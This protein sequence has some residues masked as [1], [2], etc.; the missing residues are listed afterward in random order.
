MKQLKVIIYWLTGFLLLTAV[1]CKKDY[2]NFEKFISNGPVVYP[3]RPDSTVA[4]AGKNRVQLKWPVPSD[5]NILNYKVFW[6]FGADS[7]LV[8]GR[9]PATGD[10]IKIYI[11]NLVEGSYSFTVR[12]YD[13]EDRRSVGT[14]A[15][16][17]VYG[18]I[19][20]STIFNRP[21][22]TKTLDTKTSTASIAWVGIDAKCIGT[23]WNYTNTGGAAANLFSPIGDSTI[24]TSCNVTK[25]I[26]Y[27]SLFLPEA[28]AI[29]TFYTEYKQL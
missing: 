4:L 22:R 11:A 12:S 3:G 25:P 28:N 8:T 23:Q 14:Q 2:H 20:S 24:I 17:N 26:T 19:F 27:R 7:L 10:S 16:G 15:F 1:S 21:V 6:N 5:L 13:K 29:D 9:T 18:D